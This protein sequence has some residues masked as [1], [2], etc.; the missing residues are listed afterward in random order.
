MASGLLP[1]VLIPNSRAND[2]PLSNGSIGE[3]ET[4]QEESTPTIS[5]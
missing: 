5:H 3:V 4:S 1:G 2:D